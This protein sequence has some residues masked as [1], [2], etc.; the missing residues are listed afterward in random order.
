MSRTSKLHT[1]ARLNDTTLGSFSNVPSSE[2]L[3]HLV[4]YLS[5]WSGSDKF[6]TL[7]QYTLKLIVPFLHWRA[8]LQHR[9][10]IKKDATSNAAPSL[11]SFTSIIGDARM[12]G[13]F[14]GLLPIFQWMISMERNPPPT[15]TLHTI[16]RLQGWSMLGYYPLEH[17]YYLRAHNLIPTSIP[18]L[19]AILGRSSKRISLNENKLILWSSRFWLL[20]VVLQ[21]AHLRED[22]KLLL[23]RQ[24]NLRKGKGLS[25][26]DKED[27]RKR[28]DSL[29]NELVANAANLPLALHW[30]LE[31]GIFAN[32]I[33]VTIFSL[34]NGI[35]TFRG[36][37]KATAL[38][39]VKAV[40]SPDSSNTT[41][42][43]EEIK[44]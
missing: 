13:R 15:R 23:T 44:Y 18:A 31:S 22:R 21:F 1:L 42:T 29:G 9:A 37:W 40:A 2:T 10:G 36:G 38:P 30:S 35:A 12:L 34:I 14:W 25:V 41:D 26:E 24:R 28:W 20:Y 6:F 11:A 3:N 4:R 27:L 43:V 32:D 39:S 19:S 16:E 7:I 33:W 8:R 17:L 5:T